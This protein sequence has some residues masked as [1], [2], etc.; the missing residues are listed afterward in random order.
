MAE[1]ISAVVYSHN[2]VARLPTTLLHL[3]SQ[4]SAAIPWEVLPVDS[5][6][7]DDTADVARLL[8]GRAGSAARMTRR[9]MYP[10]KR[11]RGDQQRIPTVCR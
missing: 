3:K 2:A 9:L 7:T 11:I 5:A 4:L 6:F 1:E 10:R 8:G